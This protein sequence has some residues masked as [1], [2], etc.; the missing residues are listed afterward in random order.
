M[1]VRNRF[2]I[3]YVF[4]LN[5]K[6][7]NDNN[8]INDYLYIKNDNLNKIKF[9]YLF[10]CKNKLNV[11]IYFELRKFFCVLSVVEID[12]ILFFIFYCF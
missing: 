9:L 2:K 7:F 12:V 10:C 11:V 5:D 8:K 3:D 1:K 4:F 6:K